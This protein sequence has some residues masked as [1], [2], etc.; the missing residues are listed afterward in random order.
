MACRDVETF[1]LCRYQDHRPCRASSFV[2]GVRL[3][4]SENDKLHA[5]QPPQTGCIFRLNGS[6]RVLSL[7]R[8]SACRDELPHLKVRID[9]MH[10][11]KASRPILTRRSLP[12][13]YLVLPCAR[14][15][16]QTF[17]F[18]EL[19]CQ[20]E[21]YPLPPLMHGSKGKAPGRYI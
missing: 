7:S 12:S 16:Y 18:F 8:G 9:L 21:N 5:R 17:P 15:H 19:P 20:V 11:R 1:R 2:S 13:S 6:R 10:R 4:L 14:L 3:Q